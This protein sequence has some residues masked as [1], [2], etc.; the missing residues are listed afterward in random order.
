MKKS[1]VALTVVL[2]LLVVV[3]L[4]AAVVAFFYFAVTGISTEPASDTQ[5]RLVMNLESL[6]DYEVEL[7]A[8]CAK[9]TAKR[10]I[11][12]TTE[13][14]FEHD[15]ESSSIY[16]S[17]TAEIAPTVRSAR[18]SFVLGIGAYKTGVAIGSGE[19]EPRG[20]LLT[21]GDQRYGAIVRQNGAPVGNVFVVR[22]GR[23]VH[24]LLIT[25]IYFDDARDGD[26]LFKP[27][28]EESRRL[29]LPR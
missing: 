25:G 26:D 19:L 10:N 9:L 13:I 1:T 28:L 3:G 15:C 11:D 20:E 18:E 7:D 12:F 5:K 4:A 21:V 27:L 24:A 23:V 16:V 6:D 14:E 17:S 8:K 2:G 22:Q 29:F